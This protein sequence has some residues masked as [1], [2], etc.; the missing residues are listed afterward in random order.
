MYAVRAQGITKVFGKVAALRNIGFTLRQGEMLTLLGPNG[1]GKSTLLKTIAGLYRPTTG[2]VE[3]FGHSSDA[4]DSA[5]G[6][7]SF[8]GEN[9]ALYDDLSVRDNLAFFASMYGIDA[10]NAGRSAGNLL[11]E[12]N[13]DEYMERKVGELSRGT[14]QKVAICRALM[15][16]PRLLLL[17]EPTAFLDIASSELLHS[18][19]ERLASGGA[20]VIYATQRLEE[21]YRLSGNIL[22]LNRGREEA[23]GDMRRILGKLGHVR[24]E[25]ALYREIGRAPLNALGKRWRVERRRHGIVVDVGSMDEIPLLIRDVVRRGGRIMSVTYLNKS[26]EELMGLHG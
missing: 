8:L 22:M 11:R 13:A 7:L 24:V 18:K 19:L 20:S 9:Y 21:L 1:A 15:S 14:K 3:I 26:I 23:H 6:M 17:D 5:R 4:D 12:F 16:N 10:S 25:M 2:T